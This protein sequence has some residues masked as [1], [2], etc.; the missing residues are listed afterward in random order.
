MKKFNKIHD[1]K[2][3]LLIFVLYWTS[4]KLCNF[5]LGD[6]IKNLRESKGLLQRHLANIL[7]VDTAY[8]SKVERNE[9]PLS[10]DHIK[11]ISKYFNVSELEIIDHLVATKV[12]NLI[13]EY[14]ASLIVLDLAKK[15][16]NRKNDD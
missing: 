9:K 16:I 8:V 3:I 10:K 1:N 13:R 12:V 6:Y 14:N 11:K 2:Y 7:D 5:M 15:D 4:P